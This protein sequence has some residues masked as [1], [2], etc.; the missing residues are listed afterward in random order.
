MHLLF[1]SFPQVW[2]GAKPFFFNDVSAA[3]NRKVSNLVAEISGKVNH[4]DK[5]RYVGRRAA[6]IREFTTRWK[7]GDSDRMWHDF[8]SVLY[9]KLEMQQGVIR[10]TAEQLVFLSK[11]LEGQNARGA[12]CNGY[13]LDNM[14]A[15][16]GDDEGAKL[17]LPPVALPGELKEWQWA[18]IKWPA[19]G[20]WFD[21]LRRLK[22]SPYPYQVAKPGTLPQI[23]TRCPH[24]SGEEIVEVLRSW[25]DR[26]AQ[27]GAESDEPF[28]SSGDVGRLICVD[29]YD[30]IDLV[31]EAKTTRPGGSCFNWCLRYPAERGCILKFLVETIPIEFP[32]PLRI[33]PVVLNEA[34]WVNV[35]PK[36]ALFSSGD[37]R[38][39][40]VRVGL[41]DVCASAGLGQT[42]I[43]LARVLFDR[44]S[45]HNEQVVAKKSPDRRD[46]PDHDQIGEII[47]MASAL[48]D[49][50]GTLSLSKLAAPVLGRGEGAGIE[51]SVLPPADRPPLR[52]V[53]PPLLDWAFS[54]DA[55]FIEIWLHALGPEKFVHCLLDRDSLEPVPKTLAPQRI[56]ES[57]GHAYAR[58]GLYNGM[59][60]T[61]MQTDPRKSIFLVNYLDGYTRD[62][63]AF[64]FDVSA[65]CQA[66]ASRMYGSGDDVECQGTG[67]SSLIAWTRDRAEVRTE[68]RSYA[69]PKGASKSEPLSLRDI[70]PL[71]H[72]DANKTKH[73]HYY[74]KLKSSKR[75]MTRS[76]PSRFDG[77]DVIVSPSQDPDR[78]E[79]DIFST[80]RPLC[81][82]SK[83]FV[84]VEYHTRADPF[85]VGPACLFCF[86]ES[87]KRFLGP[88]KAI[89]LFKQ[90]P[91]QVSALFS[92]RLPPDLVAYLHGIPAADPGR[93]P[94]FAVAWDHPVDP[95]IEDLGRD[96]DAFPSTRKHGRKLNLQAH[97]RQ[98]LRPLLEMAVSENGIAVLLRLMS[99]DQ[100]TT[101]D[102]TDVMDIWNEW[103]ALLHDCE[104]SR[105]KR[106][107]EGL[108]AYC[109]LN[110]QR[111]P[112][113][114]AEIDEDRQK[115]VRQLGDRFSGLDAFKIDALKIRAALANLE[116]DPLMK[117]SLED[118]DALLHG[119]GSAL[120]TQWQTSWKEVK[121]HAKFIMDRL[122]SFRG[123][124]LPMKERESDSNRVDE[125]SV[126]EENMREHAEKM[127]S[128]IA[129]IATQWDSAV[130]NV[131]DRLDQLT[132]FL[133]KSKR[134][135]LQ[136][137]NKTIAALG[138]TAATLEVAVDA[139][140]R[141]EKHLT[142]LN[143]MVRDEACAVCQGLGLNAY[144][145]VVKV[146]LATYMWDWLGKHVEPEVRRRSSRDKYTCECGRCLDCGRDVKDVC[147]C[148]EKSMEYGCMY[149]Q[150]ELCVMDQSEEK[151][152]SDRIWIVGNLLMARCKIAN[153]LWGLESVRCG[154][155]RRF[156]GGGDGDS[157]NDVCPE[158]EDDPAESK[159]ANVGR[160]DG[161][162]SRPFERDDDEGFLKFDV[163]TL[164]TFGFTLEEL[165]EIARIVQWSESSTGS[166]GAADRSG[167]R[168][169]CLM[170]IEG[171]I[172]Q[173]SQSAVALSDLF[174]WRFWD[175]WKEMKA[176]DSAYCDGYLTVSDLQALE[177]KRD[178]ALR[179]GKIGEQVLDLIW[180]V[181]ERVS[182]P[183]H[184]QA[185]PPGNSVPKDQ[186][187][188]RAIETDRRRQTVMAFFF[189]SAVRA[190]R[191]HRNCTKQ[192]KRVRRILTYPHDVSDEVL[193]EGFWNDKKDFVV[194][195]E[196]LRRA[197]KQSKDGSSERR[198]PRR[199][200]L[201]LF[202]RTSTDHG[203]ILSAVPQRRL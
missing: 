107:L 124:V 52:Y 86:A 59:L 135:G 80:Q 31:S 56:T 22:W 101:E 178:L 1:P 77:D 75:M 88:N 180:D 156:D 18:N 14:G 157:C 15:I 83:N 197:I 131:R 104:K 91:D 11:Q 46:R 153:L 201:F 54:G 194:K 19:S 93:W 69:S 123:R 170:Y 112:F 62:S 174:N 108:K 114:A 158:R 2:N 116:I 141:L 87:R 74:K 34:Y 111:I 166:D 70:D 113:S 95:C 85:A 143:A 89:D 73:H 164:S 45:G 84:G 140:M 134:S 47:D 130:S 193:Q 48:R 189:V 169:A 190:L 79:L 183:A 184:Q 33:W 155:R 7:E 40:Q 132:A 53:L 92:S 26:D 90:L 25:C 68:S 51:D 8:R 12:L 43:E 23:L 154:V 187:P 160:G 37:T 64:E 186:L 195:W 61:R 28:L 76:S 109:Y 105:A 191:G 121:Q 128:Q 127:W 119:I 150:E 63:V 66:G 65:G 16:H 138:L 106:S 162:N 196:D 17:K 36:I 100:L 97:F 82:C 120:S 126:Q 98:H 10:L 57:T 38:G 41:L 146:D 50:I 9:A 110:L 202:F 35:S 173:L 29:P 42:G 172:E 185:F 188:E 117:Q 5:F 94:F 99:L 192:Q 21:D 165:A 139:L 152:A 133:E 6:E 144:R 3:V 168:E 171:G 179:S 203:K 200:V 55:G 148:R 72:V 176:R 67:F 167:V 161:G 103:N 24:V 136:E 115:A 118:T 182:P 49:R 27:R 129:K 151:R 32:H 142:D 145:S 125:V 137:R 199:V 20:A 96:S 159:N 175:G 13:V 44:V 198:R 102:L 4:L 58:A 78:L 60:S 39:L 147:K 30:E 163:G 71:Y 149:M 177:R 181:Y 81:R 122:E